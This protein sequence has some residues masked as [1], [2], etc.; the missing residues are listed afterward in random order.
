[1]EC[2]VRVRPCVQKEN[3]GARLYF[4]SFCVL[5]PMQIG[6]IEEEISIDYEGKEIRLAI[7]IIF[8]MYCH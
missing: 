5:G 2:L 7:L 3:R 8:S 6:M 1:M 4:A